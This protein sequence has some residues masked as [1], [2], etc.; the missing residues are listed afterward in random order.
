MYLMLISLV[1]HY[2]HILKHIS[3]VPLYINSLHTLYKYHEMLLQSLKKQQKDIAAL[4][5]EATT[6]SDPAY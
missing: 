5:R 2:C 1:Y 4:Y 6:S 3:G